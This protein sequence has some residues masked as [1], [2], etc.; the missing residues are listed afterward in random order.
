MVNSTNRAPLQGASRRPCGRE[1][2]SNVCVQQRSTCE[3]RTVNSF[4]FFLWSSI[5]PP[6]VDNLNGSMTKSVASTQRSSPGPR[7]FWAGPFCV[8]CLGVGYRPAQMG[9]TDRPAQM[10]APRTKLRK[11]GGGWG[12][13]CWLPLE[14]SR[15][16]DKIPSWAQ[17]V[18]TRPEGIYR[19]VPL[20]VGERGH[21][22]SPN[23][24]CYVFGDTHLLF[25]CSCNNI[26]DTTNAQN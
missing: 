22:R 17:P 3:S 25:L 1:S 26:E 24:R 15:K 10:G 14:K 23:N 4:C 9:G 11:V 8:V 16:L 12:V 7:S 13:G 19:G 18:G 21:G 5:W 6:L 2:S 20:G